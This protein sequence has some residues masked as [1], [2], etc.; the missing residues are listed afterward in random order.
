MDKSLKWK[1]CHFDKIFITDCTGSCQNDNFKCSQWWKFHQNDNIYVSV[2]LI[3]CLGKHFRFSVWDLTWHTY[4]RSNR[5]EIQSRWHIIIS[6]ICFSVWWKTRSISTGIP[7]ERILSSAC[8][9]WVPDHPRTSGWCLTK[10]SHSHF[11]TENR[12]FQECFGY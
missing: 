6:E 3:L 9:T 10:Y 4:R 5:P 12:F 11:N 7:A 8:H 1:C 2:S